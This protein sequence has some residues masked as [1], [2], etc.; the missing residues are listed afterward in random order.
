MIN[1]VVTTCGESQTIDLLEF[2]KNSINDKFRI[3]VLKDATKDESAY[4][5]I[6]KIK[7]ER[8]NYIS[9]PMEGNFSEFRNHVHKY[10]DEDEWVLQLDADEMIER[11]FLQVLPAIVKQ[12]SNVDLL[13]LPRNNYVNGIT[14]E[15]ID[16]MGWSMGNDGRINYPDWQGR[17]Y[18]YKKGVKWKGN[19]HER[20]T[21]IKNY[22]MLKEDWAHIEHVKDFDRQ[23]KQNEY[24][25]KLEE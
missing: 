6:N 23:K 5:D 11:N 4:E 12:N 14:Q 16:K 1:I 19:V 10:I 8:I 18:K 20:V 2:L 24:Y 25:E 7:G 3:W 21:G 13:Y 15:Y 9:Y 22:G 17:L